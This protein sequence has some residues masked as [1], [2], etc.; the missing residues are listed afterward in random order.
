MQASTGQ[1]GAAQRIDDRLMVR[2][3]AAFVLLALLSAMISVGGKWIGRSIAMAGHTEDATPREIVI[4]NNVIVV[5]ANAIRFEGDRRDGVASSLR[6]YLRWPELRGY[7]AETRDDFNHAGGSRNILFVSFEP[8]IMSRDMSG[9]YD[10]I[11]SSLIETPGT[12][13]PAGLTSHDFKPQTGY[14][15]ER[16]V[17]GPEENGRRFVARCLTGTVAAESLADCER[18]LAVGDHLALVYRFP[19]RLLGDWR[20]LEAAVLAYARE[21]L[22]TPRGG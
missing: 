11:Y 3:F 6:L 13:A 4:G 1:G 16:L 17:V 8:Q 7:A 15:D 19:S 14:L 12:P 21:A 20:R 18:D 9:R 2:V 10:P 22:K 5:P